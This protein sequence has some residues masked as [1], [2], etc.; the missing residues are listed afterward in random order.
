[1]EPMKDDPQKQMPKRSLRIEG[2]KT[3][4]CLED[5]FWGALKEIAATEGVTVHELAESV[6]SRGTE[7]LSSALRVHVLTYFRKGGGAG[8]ELGKRIK[9]AKS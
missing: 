2:R 1:M 7:N 6:K 9:R 3:S 5:A 4:V 8:R